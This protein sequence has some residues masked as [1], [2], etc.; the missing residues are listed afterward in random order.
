MKKFF[1]LL[2]A[3]ALIISAFSVTAVAFADETETVA[4]TSISLSNSSKTFVLGEKHEYSINV[5]VKPDNATDKTVTFAMKNGAVAGITLDAEKGKLTIAEDC[6]AAGEHEITVTSNSDNTVKAT[7]TLKLR[8]KLDVDENKFLECI[9][10]VNK[11]QFFAMSGEFKL[12]N[13]WMKVESGEGDDKTVSAQ[14]VRDVFVGI[15]YKIEGEEGYDKDHRYDVISVESCSPSGDPKVESDW[16]SRS[17]T[18]TFSMR[19]SGW[20]LFRYVV[21]DSEGNVLAKSPIL[22]RYAVDVDH[23]V[24]ELSDTLKKKQEE[25]LVV[26]VDYSVQTSLTITDSSSTTTTYI[27]YKMVDGEWKQIYDSQSREVAE[28]YDK[29]ISTSGTITPLASDVSADKSP[30]Y[31]V[32]YTVVDNEGYVAVNGDKAEFHPEMTLFV[33]AAESDN[34]TNAVDVWKI[35]L[36]VVAGLSGVGIIVLLC[37]KPKQKAVDNRV[38]DSKSNDTDTDDNK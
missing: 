6:T 1:S 11:E 15:D 21:K 2:I 38:V 27:V 37:I 31:K 34:K 28:G 23:P 26:G 36:Y 9:D 4:A 25:G 3:L 18:S 33:K 5:S 22:T 20:W 35:V 7:F 14:N 12:G 8:N 19:T 32:V 29:N 16:T 17:L 24:V 30:V 13:E 10:D